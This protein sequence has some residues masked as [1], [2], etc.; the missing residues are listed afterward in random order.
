MSTLTNDI[1]NKLARLNALEKIIVINVI[2]FILALIIR[3]IYPAEQLFYWFEL[4]KDFFDF[5]LKPWT[6]ITYG[7]LHYGL[8][9]LLFN[10][11]VLYFVAQ[12]LLNLFNIKMALSIYFLGII[13][14]G[15]AF[16]LVYNV[17]P[18]SMIHNSG[19]LI[20][21]SAGVRAL[22]I[23]LCAY[24][25]NNEVRFFTFN[26]KLKYIGIALVVLDVLGLMSTNQGG[27]VSHLGGVLL[28]YFYAT[29]LQKGNDIGLGFQGFMDWVSNLFEPKSN[30]KTVH[31]S[32]R[33]VAGVDKKQFGEFNQQKKIDLIL[34]K[35]SKSGYESLT[36][37]E[38]TFLFKAGKD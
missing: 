38:K 37:E 20:G 10:M 17:L 12:M 25:P 15:L 21:A 13:C 6:I 33:K 24:L 7:F 3:T 35:I 1:Q 34:D 9:H 28:G 32:K 29:Q 19:P 18:T 4:P 26:I 8:F 27:Y 36:K 16:L 5:I 14:G 11:M 30:L 2:I 22:L 23:F 31:N